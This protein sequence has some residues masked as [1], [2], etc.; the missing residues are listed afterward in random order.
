MEPLWWIR[1][2]SKT[3]ASSNAV[4]GGQG[5]SGFREALNQLGVLDV[6]GL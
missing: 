1:N 6:F 3:A 5:L 4:D 2:A